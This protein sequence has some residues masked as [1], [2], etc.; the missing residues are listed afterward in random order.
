MPR[1]RNAFK[2]R[3]ADAPIID[4]SQLLHLYCPLLLEQLQRDDLF[5]PKLIVVR[6]SPGSGKSSLLRLFEADTL[7]AVY[8]R[9]SQAGDQDLVERLEQLGVLG[10]TGPRIVGIYIQCDSSLLRRR[11]SC[12]LMP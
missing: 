12:S 6:G 7:L 9:R 3:A 1:V 5:V 11:E 2:I 8:A 10:E 4:T